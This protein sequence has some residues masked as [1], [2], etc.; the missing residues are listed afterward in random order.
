MTYEGITFTDGVGDT[1][2]VEKASDGKF[3]LKSTLTMPGDIITLEFTQ[4]TI[5]Q[6]HK[7]LG[8]KLGVE[9]DGT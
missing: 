2:A 6:L 3:Y 4:E 9:N 7:W 8:E 5:I 1:F